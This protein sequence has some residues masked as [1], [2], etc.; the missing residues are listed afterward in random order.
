MQVSFPSQIAKQVSW[1]ILQLAR[2][3][4]VQIRRE[5]S[6]LGCF[7]LESYR[8]HKSLAAVSLS[9]FCGVFIFTFIELELELLGKP[10]PWHAGLKFN[11]QHRQPKSSQVESDVRATFRV[12][13]CPGLSGTVPVW[14]LV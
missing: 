9:A 6:G 7:G 13:T 8:Y 11:P 12:T 3:D 5:H 1:C 2:W 10:R 14:C 4:T